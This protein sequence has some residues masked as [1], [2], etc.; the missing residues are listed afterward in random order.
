MDKPQLLEKSLVDNSE[1]LLAADAYFRYY[2][3]WSPDSQHLAYSR[4]RS[5]NT[6]EVSDANPPHGVTKVG[7]IVLLDTRGGEEQLVTS[8][9]QWLDYMYDWSPDGQSILASSNRQTPERWQICLFPLSAAPHAETEMRV[10]A[11]D[12]KNSLWTPRFSPDGHWVSYVSQKPVGADVSVIYVI[13]AMGGGTPVRITAE[14]M[15][16]DWP[17]WSPDGKTLYFVSNYRSSFLN[18]WGIHFDPE[19]GHAV[20]EPFQVTKIESPGRM[21]S[22]Q[23]ALMEM[24]LNKNQLALPITDVSG[25]IWVLG[26]LEH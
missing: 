10:I 3:R 20:G 24:S 15:W 6:D 9:W 22:P 7:P 8:Q 16:C 17:R 4:F 26:N 2:P 14:D 11:S 1:K 23:I 5:V 21:I 19:Q 18:V 13:S 12:P 25:S